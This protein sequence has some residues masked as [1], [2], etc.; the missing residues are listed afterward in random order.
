MNTNPLTC[1]GRIVAMYPHICA[2]LLEA[3][4]I[5]GP[6]YKIFLS[7]IA[8]KVLLHFCKS[9]NYLKE[10]K[11]FFFKQNLTIYD[12]IVTHNFDV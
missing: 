4:N 10:F 5:T 7:I 2:P 11:I 12:F 3:I 1:S 6:C 9:T 8:L